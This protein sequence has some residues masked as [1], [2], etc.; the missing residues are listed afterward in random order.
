[1]ASISPYSARC[2][3]WAASFIS[4]DMPPGRAGAGETSRQTMRT[5][6]STS[7]V[8]PAH[9]CQENTLSLSGDIGMPVM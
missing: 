3:P 8:M 9:L 1:M 5:S 4:R 2:P 6:T 7:S